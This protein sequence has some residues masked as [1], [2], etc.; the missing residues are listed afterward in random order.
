LAANY[1]QETSSSPAISLHAFAS[2][3]FYPLGIKFGKEG[4]FGITFGTE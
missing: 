2:G 4:L 1:L 3:G